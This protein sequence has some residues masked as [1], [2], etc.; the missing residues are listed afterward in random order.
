MD[1][2]ATYRV[3]AEVYDRYVGGFKE[4]LPLYQ[5]LCSGRNPIL[6]I[7]SGTGRVLAALLRDKHVVTG[8]DISAEMLA[9]AEKK[10]A[11]FIRRGAL[12]LLN[13][14]FVHSG[15]STTFSAALVTFY[16]INYVFDDPQREDTWEET[17]L[18]GANGMMTL[19]QKRSMNGNF[20]ERLQIFRNGANQRE[21][22]TRRMYYDKAT[23]VGA[24]EECGFTDIE[25]TDG[26][27]L[28]G[29]HK[30]ERKEIVRGSFV[31]KAS[32]D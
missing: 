6:E 24:L 25:I 22:T 9:V 8:V 28:S 11:Y 29:F 16:T 2:V 1:A 26:Y 7:G 10:L 13:H 3:F 31:V 27:C 18:D 21:I 20:E 15:L 32:R 14:D 17:E 4:D 5:S 12:T 19:R 30:L 23:I